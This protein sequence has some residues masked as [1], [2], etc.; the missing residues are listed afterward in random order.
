LL[1]EG[2]PILQNPYSII[3]VNPENHPHLNHD[4]VQALINWL[5]D[6]LAQ[7]LIGNFRI[8]GEGLFIPD[9]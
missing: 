6:E 2:A 3:A 4:G 1:F 8:N 5:T 9:A 7:R